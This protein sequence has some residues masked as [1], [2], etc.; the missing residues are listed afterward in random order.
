MEE[1]YKDPKSLFEYQT[2]E[3]ILKCATSNVIEDILHLLMLKSAEK[4]EKN[5]TL[6]EIYNL[7]G[8]EKFTELIELLDGETVKF[9]T[10]E[11]FKEA[12]TTAVCFYYRKYCGKSWE[13]IKKL[14]GDEKLKS[15]RY[16]IHINQLSTFM[17]EMNERV[18]YRR[19][20]GKNEYDGE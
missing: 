16:S 20:H 17:K 3:T 1:L 10:K 18:E 2:N 8:V 12:L 5:L 9:P 13:E 11:Q 4:K 6:V 15:I 7:L 14:L 19:K